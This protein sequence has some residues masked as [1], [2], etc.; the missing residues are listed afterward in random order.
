MYPLL[1]WAGPWRL[2]ERTVTRKDAKAALNQDRGHTRHNSL[3]L[4]SEHTT[5]YIHYQTF[6]KCAVVVIITA[7]FQRFPIALAVPSLIKTKQ[8]NS[9]HYFTDPSIQ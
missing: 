4:F 5:V 1:A 7:N 9:I 8:K 6:M 3:S 2:L